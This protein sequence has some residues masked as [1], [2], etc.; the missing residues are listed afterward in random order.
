MSTATDRQLAEQAAGGD[1][2]AFAQLIDRHYDRIYRMAWRWLGRRDEAEDVAQDVCIKIAGAIRDFRA[3][4]EFSTWIWRV[5]F[6]TATDVLRTRQ[7]I[8][9]TDAS[10]VMNLVEGPA[11][12]TPEDDVIG[13]ELWAAVRTLPAQ[14]RDAVLL[15][16]G[17]DMN[18]AE[19][20][21]VLGCTEKTV[22]WH[23]HAAR[24]S[25]RIHLEAVG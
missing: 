16:Y 24:K 2:A 18:H 3:D 13:A 11:H 10:D 5:T 20:A 12:Q 9:P 4:A 6:N 25:L 19:A 8:I 23:L 7:R 15:V 22:S 14:Q 21:A 1:R 17:E